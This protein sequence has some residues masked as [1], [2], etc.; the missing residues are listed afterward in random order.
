MPENRI[1]VVR[2]APRH[3]VAGHPQRGI[4]TD[5]RRYLFALL[6]PLNIARRFHQ[7]ATR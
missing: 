4:V 1:L 6:M 7:E 3:E 5:D 2:L